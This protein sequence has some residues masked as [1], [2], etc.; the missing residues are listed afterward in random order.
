MKKLTYWNCS[1]FQKMDTS[2]ASDLNTTQELPAE[3]VT[4][5]TRKRRK[6][7]TVD[8]IVECGVCTESVMNVNW[9]EHIRIKHNYLAKR[10]GEIPLVSFIVHKYA[11]TRCIL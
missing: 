2:T 7:T 8:E 3:K 10:A 6:R 4:Q 11:Y 5:K 9:I 1:A